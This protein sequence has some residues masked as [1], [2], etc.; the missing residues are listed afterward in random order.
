MSVKYCPVCKKTVQRRFK[1]HC[2]HC[3]QYLIGYEGVWIEADEAK[4]PVQLIKHFDRLLSA[5]DSS[6]YN[7]VINHMTPKK[8]EGWKV[9]V[10]TAKQLWV[11]ADK[12]LKLAKKTMEILFTHKKFAWKN[13]ESLTSLHHDWHIGVAIAKAQLKE[14]EEAR[15]AEDRYYEFTMRNGENF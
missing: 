4:P 1:E 8:G 13:R 3:G 11:K 5:K 10:A 2:P 14:I 7:T 9:A 12:D 6:E 15:S